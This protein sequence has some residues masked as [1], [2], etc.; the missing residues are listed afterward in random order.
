[1][2]PKILLH[3]IVPTR[4]TFKVNAKTTTLRICYRFIHLCGEKRK[5]EKSMKEL[6]DEL[7]L[8]QGIF[9]NIQIEVYLS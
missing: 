9:E 3:Q 4:F 7:G 1:M 8:Y 6:H 5:K 2:L